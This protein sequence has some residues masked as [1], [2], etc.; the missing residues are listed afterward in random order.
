[1]IALLLSFCPRLLEYRLVVPLTSRAETKM[2][3]QK[4]NSRVLPLAEERQEVE[5]SHRYLSKNL[6]VI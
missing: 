6:I 2:T 1:M 4:Q 5:E 3:T